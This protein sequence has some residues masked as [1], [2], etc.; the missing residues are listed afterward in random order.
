MRYSL[1]AVAVAST[2]TLAACNQPPNS[3]ESNEPATSA[4]STTAPTDTANVQST[5]V[6]STDNVSMNITGAGASFPQPIYA[7]W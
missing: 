6:Q 2:F 1:M 5:D 3:N 7:K 4:Q